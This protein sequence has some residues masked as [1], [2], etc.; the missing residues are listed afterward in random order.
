M[1]FNLAAEM[2]SD[3]RSDAFAAAFLCKGRAGSGN[4]FRI[5]LKRVATSRLGVDC[6]HGNRGNNENRENC[7]M[8]DKRH[9]GDDD[10]A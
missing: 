10:G 8:I 7:V 5:S 6:V 9:R 1:T 2:E 3:A 4:F